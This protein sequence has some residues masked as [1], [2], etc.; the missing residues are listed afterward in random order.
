MKA[1]KRIITTILISVMLI[2]SINVS[3]FAEAMKEYI[4]EKN[5]LAA[6]YSGKCG[7]NIT[8]ILDDE[9]TLTI[10][11]EGAIHNEKYRS[12]F[13]AYRNQIVNVIIESGVTRIGDRVFYNL[14]NMKSVTI[15]PSVTEF[16]YYVFDRC[17][18]LEAVYISDITAWCGVDFESYN[19]NSN[20]L[21][22]ACNLYLNGELVEE[23]VIPEGVEDIA[24]YV[25][26]GCKSIKSVS[27]PESLESIGLSEFNNC[28]SLNSVY[29][30]DLSAW[31]SIDIGSTM[32]DR[33]YDLYLDG[34]V[35]TDL[36]IPEDI[37][38]LNP[39]TFKNVGSILSV[40]I[41]ENVKSISFCVFEGCE[42][43]KDIS[44]SD[45]CREI[46][47]DCFTDTAFYLDE[48]NW[49]NGALYI[50]SHLIEVKTELT[51]IYAIR[52]GILTI[53][54]DAFYFSNLEAVTMTDS[55]VYITRGAF[56]FSKIKDVILSNNITRI[57]DDTFIGS[58]LKSVK[59][60]DN[61][62]EIGFS[63]FDGTNLSSVVF[64]D[65]LEKIECCAFLDCYNLVNISLGK[66]I[67]QIEVNAFYYSGYYLS[68]AN[69]RG[70]NLYLGDWL[71]CSDYED[72]EGHLTVK[73]GTKHLADAAFTGC[74]EVKSI[75]LSEGITVLPSYAFSGCSS[76]T[77]F[78]VPYGVTEIKEKAF[79]VCSSLECVFIPET[80]TYIADDAFDRC[81]KAVIFCSKGSYAEEYAI[82][83]GIPV[84][85]E[86]V[87]GK[88][89]ENISW[90][91]TE[92]GTLKIFG[93]GYM[94]E[95]KRPSSLSWEAY[96]DDITKVII[97]DGILNIAT[98][99]FYE[100][101]NLKEVDFG[102]T[103]ISIG[104]YAFY[105]AS[106]LDNIVF[107]DSCTT[108]GGS[109]FA[110]VGAQ[111][112]TLPK[113]ITN[114]SGFAFAVDKHPYPQ[115]V[116]RCY[117]G[118]Y[119]HEYLLEYDNVYGCGYVLICDAHS[120][121]KYISNN[122]GSCVNNATETAECDNCYA[123]DTREIP[124]SKVH[125]YL[126]EEID[127]GTCF[128]KAVM[129]YTCSGCGDF[130]TEETKTKPHSYTAYS[131]YKE[132]TC[133]ANRIDV[134]YCDYG[135]GNYKYAVIA[136][137]AV[138]H[139]FGDY[140]YNNNATCTSNGT[141]T[142]YCIY[143]CGIFSTLSVP[144]TAKGH[145]LTEWETII[146]ATPTSEGERKRECL[147]CSYSE[148]EIVPCLPDP[149]IK[150]DGYNVLITKS[151]NIKYIRYAMGEYSTSGD[152]KNAEGCE[153]LDADTILSLTEDSIASIPI[154][155]GGVYSFWIKYHDGNEFIYT[156]DLAEME[157]EIEAEGVTLTVKNLYGVKDYF[158]AKGDY[159]T[160]ADVK[161]NRVVQITRNKIGTK[162][163][164][165][166]ILSEAGVYTVCVRYDDPAREY[167]LMTV[168]LTVTEPV[169]TENGLQL[170]VSNLRDIKVIRTA[171]GDH[172]T[173]GQIKK[174]EE[175]RAFTGKSVLNGLNVY[176][177]QYR[178]EG[179]VTV[180]VVYNNGYE[181]IYKYNVTKKSPEIVREG[182]LITF[183]NLEDFKVIR[184]AEG[185]YT[186]ASEIK[187]AKGSVGISGKHY[188][189]DSYTV[190]LAPGTYTFC[191]Q[192][193]DESYNYYRITVE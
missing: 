145:S 47:T 144:D 6:A 90:L 141:K 183:N 154:N 38:Q 60:P 3:S 36:V 65:S 120:F 129:K 50:D 9:G 133:I 85:C 136:S 13:D 35:I 11:G 40:Y 5:E 167:K 28:S 125:N 8:W 43:L 92:E 131:V 174:A 2:G 150:L 123:T 42:N 156:V 135:C 4:D 153:T 58:K 16:G 18:S 190:R 84:Q 98:A 108:I 10:S 181:V 46:R 149:E 79:N 69:W 70:D 105:G 99:A 96:K 23:L 89:G 151:N 62:I 179:L 106:S 44:I 59:L 107:P 184:Y 147:N 68:S 177:I 17:S 170:K 82:K 191:V 80:V 148:N 193:D 1:F 186:T 127:P 22:N 52:P 72:A 95:N 158:I 164:Y 21:F 168:K 119:A 176:T 130:Y 128:R 146:S 103:V 48:S 100:Y 138:G 93:S 78:T 39:Y 139:R 110:Y 152:I 188:L 49:D 161:A 20:P 114:I 159:T 26:A 54:E 192:Y 175:S 121:T 24:D 97:G 112:I 12:C 34:E 132:P 172:S 14:N 94:Y 163:D 86:Y 143:G 116:L 126:G 66:N 32:T 178:D 113:T 165:S 41:P 81:D 104:A 76:L 155:D 27:F 162:H 134:S 118:S 64:P 142:A 111:Y 56:Q 7:N 55:V 122:D 140:I 91:L 63:A 160:Y 88:C 57:N 173:P 169:F 77:E 37:E 61:L 182:D 30:K 15:P 185:V 83:Q 102:N 71:I 109:A 187:N 45:E 171:Y 87:T 19:T 117:K 157:Q 67:K 25:F 101:E 137:T 189:Y 51:G 180:A 53:A 74:T 73:Q 166:Y 75:E 115:M 33:S 31:C 29:I 124:N